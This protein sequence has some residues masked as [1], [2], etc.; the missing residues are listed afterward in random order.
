MAGGLF[1]AAG[2]LAL[3]VALVVSLVVSG[4]NIVHATGQNPV[5]TLRV[6]P[7]RALL[8]RGVEEKRIATVD[9]ATH[10]RP[11]RGDA[12]RELRR[13]IGRHLGAARLLVGREQRVAEAGERV[14][15][16]GRDV[17]RQPGRRRCRRRTSRR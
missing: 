13:E 17:R 3:L 8:A 7:D 5:P 15:E 10:E 2:R 16:A 11:R 14:V 9:H 12:E 6:A 4:W 1:G